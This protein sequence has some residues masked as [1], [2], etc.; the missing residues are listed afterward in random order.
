MQHYAKAVVAHHEKGL[1][2]NE[3]E[4]P[5]NSKLLQKNSCPGYCSKFVPAKTS[6][7]STRNTNEIPCMLN[8]S[9]KHYF[10]PLDPNLDKK[11]QF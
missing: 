4:I 5:S 1:I 8:I 10:P 3:S 9:L 6:C 11:K 7:Y 2:K